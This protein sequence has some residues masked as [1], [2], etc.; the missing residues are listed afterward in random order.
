MNHLQ[1]LNEQR[2][3]IV[4]SSTLSLVLIQW[5]NCGHLNYAETFKCPDDSPYSTKIKCGHSLI[6]I[7]DST[8][9][10]SI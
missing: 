9:C 7:A 6:Q 5:L 3:H 2:N 1:S 4:V 8:S 10:T